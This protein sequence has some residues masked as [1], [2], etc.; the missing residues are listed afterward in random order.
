MTVTVI[1][2]IAVI[3]VLAVLVLLLLG[4]RA[5]SS[6]S[7]EDDYDDEY[8]HEDAEGDDRDEERPRGRGRGRER[9]RDGGRGRGGSRGRDLD[10]DEDDGEPEPRGRSRRSR[11]GDGAKAERRPRGRR[12]LDADWDD[13]DDSLSD[14]DFWSSLGE[15]GPAQRPSGARD[16]RGDRDSAVT[17]TA[18]EYEDDDY[19]DGYGDYEDEE[20]SG[21]PGATTVMPA[22]GGRGSGDPSADLAVLASLGQGSG[23]QPAEEDGEEPPRGRGRRRRGAEPVGEDE[24]ALPP[25][26][27]PRSALPPAREATPPQGVPQPSQPAAPAA[28]VSDDPLG[29]GS[30]SPRSSYSPSSTDPLGSS[31]G[32]RDPLGTPAGTHDPLGTSSGR[33]PLGGSGSVPSAGDPF[34]GRSSYDSGSMSRSDYPGTAG[35]RSAPPADPLDPAFQRPTPGTGTSSPIWSSMDT[36]AHQRSELGFGGGQGGA[37]TGQTSPGGAVDPADPLSGGYRS[38]PETSHTTGTHQRSSYDTGSHQRSSYDTG[39]HQ[40]SSY[41]TGAHSHADYGMSG[42]G[43]PEY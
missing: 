37:G 8:E 19:D 21:P 15:D 35:A 34:Q 24:R 14:N 11:Q 33:D 22:A 18:H 38:R 43:R 28:S 29:T 25:G 9:A 12:K 10:E 41:D 39:A 30:W 36:G 26:A 2:I 23:P 6:G 40:R 3:V 13:D 20:A 42:T 16:G 17:V 27:P 31:S 5:L 4:M 7:R 1:I 32:T